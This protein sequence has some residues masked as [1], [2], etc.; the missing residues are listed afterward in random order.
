MGW[1]AFSQK[2]KISKIG[3]QAL[4]TQDLQNS[5]KHY[6]S[7]P[8]WRQP[9]SELTSPH[10]SLFNHCN[11]LVNVVALVLDLSYHSILSP[12]QLHLSW[13]LIA[14]T[15]LVAL[16]ETGTTW[17][18]HQQCPGRTQCRDLGQGMEQSL[19]KVAKGCIMHKTRPQPLTAHESVLLL[20]TKRS[21]KLSEHQSAQ[22]SSVTYSLQRTQSP[23]SR[24]QCA[25][26]LEQGKATEHISNW[27]VRPR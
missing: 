7:V 14:R 9:S 2:K 17:C 25:R 13:N 19:P 26:A 3:K 5:Q 16:Q 6:L 10:E 20:C 11:V 4:V 18:L 24:L 12:L 8:K 1:K 23:T 27:K 21:A 15:R 22:Q